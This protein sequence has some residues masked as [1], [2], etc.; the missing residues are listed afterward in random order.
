MWVLA[1]VI[2]SLGWSGCGSAESSRIEAS[3]EDHTHTGFKS[4]T[5]LKR[6]RTVV[7]S[8]SVDGGITRTVPWHA[9]PVK[10]SRVLE[11]LLSY[12]SCG[13]ALP[14]V[15]R[16][17]INERTRRTTVTAFV[18]FPAVRHRL[19]SECLQTRFLNPVKISLIEEAFDRVLYDGSTSPP[20]KRWS[21]GGSYASPG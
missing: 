21:P 1:V 18:F 15:Q 4:P 16:I 13:I 20:S 7:K 17:E 2:L 5:T 8:R 19:R 14:R 11:L 6:E 3:A 12:S 10:G 9:K